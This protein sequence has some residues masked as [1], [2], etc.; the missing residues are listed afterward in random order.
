[1]PLKKKIYLFIAFFS[2]ISSITALGYKL[3]T[4]ADM[5]YISILG[6]MGCGILLLY[7]IYSPQIEERKEE[8]R[9]EDQ[10]IKRKNKKKK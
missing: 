9:K 4:H 10:K 7:F 1:M 6:G 8:Q 2:I 5:S 3:I